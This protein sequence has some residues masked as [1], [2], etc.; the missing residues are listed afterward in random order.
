MLLF[1]RSAPRQCARTWRNGALRNTMAAT[2][3]PSHQGPFGA[4]P[5]CLQRP[6]GVAVRC[7]DGRRGQASGHPHWSGRRRRA[8]CRVSD[9]GAAL[10][11]TRASAH[12]RRAARVRG[13]RGGGTQHPV[14]TGRLG[15]RDAAG[16][17]LN[18]LV[19]RSRSSTPAVGPLS[20][21]VAAVQP[22]AAARGLADPHRAAETAFGPV[23][24]T[25]PTA[26]CRSR[27]GAKSLKVGVCGVEA[28]A[29]TS[30]DGGDGGTS[31]CTRGPAQ[32]HALPRMRGRAVLGS[33][34]GGGPDPQPTLPAQPMPR[35]RRGA[36]ALDRTRHRPA[37]WVGGARRRLASGP[38]WGTAVRRVRRAWPTST[39]AYLGP[40]MSGTCSSTSM[41]TSRGQGSSGVE[42]RPVR[43][44]CSQPGSSISSTSPTATSSCHSS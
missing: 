33:G 25:G 11:P 4:A 34:L 5:S 32:E 22:A 2:D 38:W 27:Y 37:Q 28:V 35:Y 36:L 20:A 41:G 39:N 31:D 29:N 1:S 10:D 3:G 17:V 7:A 24:H 30:E 14:A 40:S 8:R 13:S 21:G 19:E 44:S 43:L 26:R 16:G 6:G 12:G 23:R 15:D 18:G 9:R 42:V